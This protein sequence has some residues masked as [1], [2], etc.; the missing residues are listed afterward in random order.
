M[1]RSATVLFLCFA[2]LTPGYAAPSAGHWFTG[3][4]SNKAAVYAATANDDGFVFG[5][6]CYFSEKSCSWYVALD[7]GC[8]QNSTYP[9]L[10][11]T[12]K[13]AATFTLK[14]IGKMDES[15]YTYVFTNWKDL[16]ALIMTGARLGIATPLQSDQF[17]V[18]RF[19]LDGLVATTGEVEKDFFA[20]VTDKG[21][22]RNV[23]STSSETL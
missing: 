23:S 2:I 9:I 8:E 14:C 21:K 18:Y 12:D 13:G 7:M 11:S 22:T 6:Y 4:T 10:A 19:S 1:I 3:M 20:A 16:E 15:H 17:R 5:Q